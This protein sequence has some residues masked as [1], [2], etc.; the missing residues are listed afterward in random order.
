M[1]PNLPI[2]FN[3]FSGS[4]VRKHKECTYPIAVTTRVGTFVPLRN[5]CNYN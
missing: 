3:T 2:H 1:K 5:V 4:D